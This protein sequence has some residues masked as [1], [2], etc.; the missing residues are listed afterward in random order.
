MSKAEILKI[1]RLINIE[2]I[3]LETYPPGFSERRAVAGVAEELAKTAD[4]VRDFDRYHELRAIPI[5]ELSD[6]E[7]SEH[8]RLLDWISDL[9]ILAGESGADTEIGPLSVEIDVILS[10]QIQ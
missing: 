4:P 6:A 9:I 1:K 2:I 7:A 3:E 8:D 5:A 10:E